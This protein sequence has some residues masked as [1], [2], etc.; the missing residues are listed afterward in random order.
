VCSSLVPIFASPD[1]NPKQQVGIVPFAA[2]IT[3][4]QHIPGAVR[5]LSPDGDERLLDPQHLLPLT[6][7]PSK[8]TSGFEWLAQRLPQLIGVPYLWGGKSPFGYDCSGLV[9]TL[10]SL[11]DIHLLRDADQQCAQGTPVD[12]A[13]VTLGDLLFFDTSTPLTELPDQPT[14]V[15]HVA[16]ALDRTTFFHASRRDGDGVGW[17][18]F[19]PASPYFLPSHERRLVGARRYTGA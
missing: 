1:R 12:L 4:Q 19:D 2:R 8:D 11:L 16:F 13:D 7:I 5:I 6:E 3:V 14:R 9:Q 10:Y 18:S 15:T 17:G